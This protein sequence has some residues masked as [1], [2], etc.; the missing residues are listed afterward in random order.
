MPEQD[1]PE[2]ATEGSKLTP[3]EAALAQIRADL[4]GAR[5]EKAADALQ[6]VYAQVPWGWVLEPGE[7][8][9]DLSLQDLVA[10]AL[11]AASVCWSGRAILNERL[12]EIGRGLLAEL[13]KRGYE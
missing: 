1:S 13:E 12:D 4:E 7:R 8:V 9:E 6:A 10:Q 3:A 2:S 5:I 11:G